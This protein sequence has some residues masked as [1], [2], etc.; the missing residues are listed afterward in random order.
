[1]P[2]FWKNIVNF[3]VIPHNLYLMKHIK[4]VKLLGE[5]LIQLTAWGIFILFGPLMVWLY[6]KDTHDAVVLL[7]ML[8]WTII[9]TMIVYFLNYYLLVPKLFLKSAHRKIWYFAINILILSLYGLHIAY[10]LFGISYKLTHDAW[11]GISA[12][13]TV[14]LVLNIGSIGLAL[15][16]RNY[17]R[18][19]LIKL[20]LNEEKRRR[21]EAE[22]MW[23]KNQLNPHFL[24]NSLNNISSLVC[25]DTDKA[26]E[27]IGRLSDLLRYAI[28]DSEKKFVSLHK[29][30][31]F[32]RNYIE[33]MSLR[34]NDK[35]EISYK[36][37]YEDENMQIVPLVLVAIIENAFKHGVST[38][39][40]SF[41]RFSIS[42]KDG[43]L[44]FIS[45]NSNHAKPE[46][47]HSGSGIGLANTK[48]R[49]D[50]IYGDKYTWN[51]FSD[52]SLFRIEITIHEINNC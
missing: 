28:Y 8:Q 6:S 15:A 13:L 1:M 36:F 3:A 11:L 49:L 42:E 44:A 29:E 20:Q 21:T 14:I 18:S 37:S 50:M 26:Q 25:I 38:V 12:A 27:C 7:Y 45:E 35:T 52:A 34:C 39:K 5:L 51:Q 30:I 40:N 4:I 24:F 31:E 16:I 41:I 23:L 9:P 2:I 32:I 19:Q 10:Q 17:Q 43:V 47:D 46:S 48:K 22:L 33:L